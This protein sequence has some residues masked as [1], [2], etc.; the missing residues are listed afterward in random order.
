MRTILFALLTL[1][2]T[3]ALAD[4]CTY[5][6]DK[7]G[8]GIQWTAFKTPTKKG[9]P[10]TFD[11]IDVTLPQ[12]KSVK[13]ALEGATATIKTPSVNTKNEGRDETL[14]KSFFGLIK[15]KVITGK[16]QNVMAGEN[17]G[18][19]DLVVSMHGQTHPIPMTYSIAG[20]TLTAMGSF[21]MLH[22]GMGELLASVSKACY[23]LHSGVTWSQ[24]EL[25]LMGKLSKECR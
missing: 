17:L 6:I 13:E 8:L 18:T 1:F 4:Q 16:I 24:V 25:Q 3:A 2:A 11:K 9:V 14:V 15:G 23:D 7:E 21:D 10:G 22:F 19:F 5:Q 20:D 12:G